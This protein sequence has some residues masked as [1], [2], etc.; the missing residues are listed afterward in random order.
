FYTLLRGA[1]DKGKTVFM[2][3]HVLSEVDRVCDRIAL[4]RK[5]DLVLLSTLE[6][7]RKMAARHIRVRFREAVAPP[8]LPDG[9]Q[10]TECQP[11][12]WILNVEGPLGP[13][14]SVIA[15]LPVEDI[16]VHEAKLED[17]VMKYY[18]GGGA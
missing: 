5:G 6:E 15:G 1:K 2:S 3:S 14:L 18:R 8:R 11:R 12:Q 4:M 10:M 9:C 13:L 7:I 17:V 16:D